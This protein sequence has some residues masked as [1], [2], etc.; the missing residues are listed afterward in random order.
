MAVS[1]A[2]RK[3]NARW[4][5]ENTTMVGVQIKKEEAKQFK[6]VCGQ[7]GVTPSRVLR[8]AM[9]D[10]VQQVTCKTLYDL[11]PWDDFVQ[12]HIHSIIAGDDES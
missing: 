7:S 8:T 9:N 4:N 1:E 3:A 2:K 11:E 5:K 10:Y 12:S 6:A